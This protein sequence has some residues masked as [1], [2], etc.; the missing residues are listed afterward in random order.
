[1]KREPLRRRLR[2]AA[3]RYLDASI[4]PNRALPL[5]L[6]ELVTEVDQAVN[7]IA[8]A[9][10]Q[11]GAVTAED[12]LACSR[13]VDL[14][15]RVLELTGGSPKEPLLREKIHDLAIAMG[16]VVPA[17]DIGEPYGEPRALLLKMREHL[18][19]EVFLQRCAD[20]LKRSRRVMAKAKRAL[21][22]FRG[23]RTKTSEL[24]AEQKKAAAKFRKKVGIA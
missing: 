17:V 2:G 15:S 1:M 3:E 5:P 18:G 21:A 14:A 20:R 16:M 11:L 13:G 7:P 12:P 19:S 4:D 22:K 23:K 6:A 8:L 10:A 9:V 24:V